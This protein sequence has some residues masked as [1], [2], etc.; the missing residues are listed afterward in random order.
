VINL[1]QLFQRHVRDHPDHLAI[2]GARPPCRLTYRELDERMRLAGAGLQRAGL[3]PGDCV[4]LHFASGV[5]Y[6]VLT[7]AVWS[8]GG[9][10]VP[11][12][13]ELALPEKQ[14]ICRDIA[15]QFVIAEPASAAF[16]E[17]LRRAATV[18]LFAGAG[19]IPV[20]SP[21]EVPDGLASLNA[22]FIRFTSGTT[23]T[24]KGVVLSHET[25]RDRVEAANAVLG[26]GP[27][28]RV[29]WLLS[30]SYHFAVTIA[31]YLSLGATILLPANHF[32]PAVLATARE[33]DATLIYGSP[34]HFAWMSE[35]AGAAPLPA[36]RLAISTTAALPAA[37]GDK[38]RR[39]FELP[40][41][42]ALGIIEV[43]L[44]FINVAGDRPDA[45]GRLLPAYRLQ[46]AE[47][48]LGPNLG[49]VL[50]QGPGLLDAYY[51]P[52]R[53]R[54][55]I[56]PD[57]WFHTGDVG[58]LAADGCLFLRGRT[59]DLISVLGMK[60]FPQE[61]EAVLALHPQ[62]AAACA[63]ARPDDRL[64]EVPRARVV[65]RGTAGPSLERDLLA[66]CRERLAA[67]KVPEQIEFVTELPRTASGK[68][69]RR[70]PR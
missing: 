34:S 64:G 25:I 11:I 24:S 40:I 8:R 17:P 31:G 39:R 56:M 16:A 30:M 33:H 57:G 37:T 18:E 58:E 27:A 45:V 55:Q 14:E 50:L 62:V 44:P 28:D 51:Q 35:A 49:E 42:Q 43:G 21:R 22:A 7:Y 67:Y 46:L 53:T 65:A 41:T 9:C 68:L 6:I 26:I 20:T 13:P 12:P 1:Y 19:L 63:Y 2:V 54:G 60:F 38:F 5:D 3:R 66:L 52:W 10:V 29:V 70:E 61:I 32:A 4:G 48:G 47:A 59:K 15:L 69:L 36:L 23:G